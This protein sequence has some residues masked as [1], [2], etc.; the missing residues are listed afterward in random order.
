MNAVDVVNLHSLAN[1]R[2]IKLLGIEVSAKDF[3]DLKRDLYALP[4]YKAP[5]DLKPNEVYVSGIKVAGKLCECGAHPE[6]W[7]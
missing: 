7:E 4:A 2:E 1:I 5:G 3:K 6:D